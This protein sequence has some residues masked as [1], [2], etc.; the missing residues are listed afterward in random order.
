MRNPY[1]KSAVVVIVFLGFMGTPAF[2][3]PSRHD[4]GDGALLGPNE[5][6][7]IRQMVAKKLGITDEQKSELKKLRAKRQEIREL[8]E[9]LRDERQE[10][11]QLLRANDTNDDDVKSKLAKVNEMMISFNNIRVESL[12]KLKEV[13]T[14]EQRSRIRSFIKSRKQMFQQ[15]MGH[16]GRGGAGRDFGKGRGGPPGGFFG[17]GGKQGGG[18]PSDDL[19]QNSLGLDGFFGGGL[20]F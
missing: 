11:I 19:L 10:L 5:K 1:L 3:Q 17:R 8:G 16:Q 20:L 18:G 4:G 6:A 15:R 7:Q 13:L 2:A 9:A 12:L 14:P